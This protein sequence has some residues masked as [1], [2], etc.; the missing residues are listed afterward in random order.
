M[1]I[2]LIGTVKLSEILLRKLASLKADVAHVFTKKTSNFNSD[3][4]DLGITCKKFGIP[5]SYARSINT[6]KNINLVRGIGPDVIF[7][8][9]WSELLKS[10]LLRIPMIGTIGYH[11]ALLPQNRGRHPLIWAL[12]LGLSETGSTFFFMKEGIDDGDILSQRKVRISYQDNASS[13]YD[14]MAKTATQQI[15]DFLPLLASGKIVKIKQDRFK[16]TYWRKR[17]VNDGLIDWR[18]PS[19][20]VYNLIRAL[21][22]PYPGAHFT[23]RDRE[24]KVW[25]AKE[26]KTCAHANIEPG[27][28]IQARSK[29]EFLIKTGKGC[30]SIKTNANLPI[31]EGD[32]L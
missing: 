3:F 23:Y 15:D 32:Y 29:N 1:K 30:I 9:G 8:F 5:Y 17:A 18:M 24:I 27:K 26:V 19:F 31:K 28:V 6:Q 7:C 11:P 20:S 12:A 4:F 22:R 2:V 25:S 13:L 14:K 10:E 21:T 16:A